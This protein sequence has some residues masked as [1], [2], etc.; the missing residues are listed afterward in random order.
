MTPAEITIIIILLSAI[1]TVFFIIAVIISDFN[2]ET[3]KLLKQ[4]RDNTV[5]KSKPVKPVN[6]SAESTRV[7]RFADCPLCG[8]RVSSSSKHCDKCGIEIDW[9]DV[10]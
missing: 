6:V 1:L 2:K 5:D 4:I 3:N 7:T 9:S 10:K 8:R